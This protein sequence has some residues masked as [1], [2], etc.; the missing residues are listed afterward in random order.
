VVRITGFTEAGGKIL[1][2]TELHVDLPR[3]DSTQKFNV[4]AKEAFKGKKGPEI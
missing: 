2:E 4:D 1:C 3:A